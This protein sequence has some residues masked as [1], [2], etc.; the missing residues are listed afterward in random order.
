MR[1]LVYRGIIHGV[2]HITRISLNTFVTP[3]HISGNYKEN[4]SAANNKTPLMTEEP[5]N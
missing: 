1:A 3:N 4:L 2:N 5:P